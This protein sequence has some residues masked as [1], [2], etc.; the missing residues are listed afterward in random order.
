M[1]IVENKE[2]IET[3]SVIPLKSIKCIHISSVLIDFSLILI[4]KVSSG[5][6]I[7]LKY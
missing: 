5:L 1:H 3:W 7:K 6:V 4:I 2:I